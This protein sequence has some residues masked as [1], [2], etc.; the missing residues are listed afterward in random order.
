MPLLG[1]V[2]GTVWINRLADR[3]WAAAEERIRALSAA[4]SEGDARR[5]P[6]HVT[7]ASKE[8]QIHF[9]AAIRLAAQRQSRRDEAFDLAGRGRRGEGL[10]AVLEEAQEFLD[11]LHQGARRI[12]A[13]PSDAP[14]R[15]H[16]EWD[17]PTL[18]FMMSCSVLRARRQRDR[19]APVDAAESLI[20][21]LHLGQ[22]WS[23]SGSPVNR[24]V[25]PANTAALMEELRDLLSSS[26]W[27]PQELLR[28]ER[29]LEPLDAALKSPLPDLER[30][31]AEWG[32]SLRKSDVEQLGLRDEMS[33]RWK[34]LVPQRLMKADA[35]DFFDRQVRLLL[36]SEGKGYPELV[37]L[38][39]LGAEE[40]GRSSNPLLGHIGNLMNS[41]G[42]VEL[43]R[44]AQFR[45]LRTAAHYR[46][47]GEVLKIED[48]YG[49]F[50]RHAAAPTGMKF[51]SCG[52]DGADD[53][54]HTGDRKG[55]I[56]PQP[57]AAPK[58]L[59]IEVPRFK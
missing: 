32:E 21:A 19:N 48:P 58:D 23:I 53:G 50:I 44:K 3:R 49:T 18:Q 34:Y 13:V 31:L 30:N 5:D 41:I 28:I 2:V 7:E 10:D 15:W 43:D 57:G 25:A 51:W 37:R 42:W 11:R 29:E 1:A 59:V 55:W 22:F 12:A 9:V 16:G 8:N 39:A 54:G 47:T 6:D 4:I 20:D 14:P 38:G 56:G 36:S 26:P 46:A 52:D 17:P 35:I 40:S 24:S 45:L 33:F 27:S